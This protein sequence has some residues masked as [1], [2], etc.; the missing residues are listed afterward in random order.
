MSMEFSLMD[1]PAEKDKRQ[2]VCPVDNQSIFKD[3]NT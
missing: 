1:Y 3:K 2:L